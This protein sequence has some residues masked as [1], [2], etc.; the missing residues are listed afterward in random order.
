M[1]HYIEYRFHGNHYHTRR[2]GPLNDLEGNG[3][4]CEVKR[5]G[6]VIT[7]HKESTKQQIKEIIEFRA[8]EIAEITG[9]I[10]NQ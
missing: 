1:Y 10:I 2:S 5:R 6:G 7:Y 3:L 8:N 9:R 4:I